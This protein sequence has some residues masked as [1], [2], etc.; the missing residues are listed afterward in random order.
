MLRSWE[1]V[2]CKHDVPKC[3]KFLIMKGTLPAKTSPNTRGTKAH[4][5]AQPRLGPVLVADD[6]VALCVAGVALTA[7]GGA[8]GPV[9]VAG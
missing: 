7:L 6:A 2:R 4:T 9:L 3:G 5:K 1:R 8:L